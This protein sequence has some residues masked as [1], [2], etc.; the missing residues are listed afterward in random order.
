MASASEQSMVNVVHLIDGVS[1]MT[2]VSRRPTRPQQGGTDL[3]L[4][5]V[6]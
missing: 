6:E 1:F 5:S 3:P 2:Q 4:G